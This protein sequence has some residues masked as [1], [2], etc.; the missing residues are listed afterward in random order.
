MAG[1]SS[2]FCSNSGSASRRVRT[3]RT[4]Y[5]KRWWNDHDITAFGGNVAGMQYNDDDVEDWF[6]CHVDALVP[7][8]PFSIKY[9]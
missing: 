1:G 7:E 4:A 8:F 3:Q 6:Q 9:L 5:L 2:P